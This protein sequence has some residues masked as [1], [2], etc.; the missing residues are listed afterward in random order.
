MA[1]PLNNSPFLDNILQKTTYPFPCL[2]RDNASLR[3]D[4]RSNL[5]LSPGRDCFG[6][7]V[8]R[9]DEKNQ[10]RGIEGERLNLSNPSEAIK[11]KY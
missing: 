9:N 4:R 2:G 3:A 11:T 1:A 8:P 6:A 5:F 10:E 7:D